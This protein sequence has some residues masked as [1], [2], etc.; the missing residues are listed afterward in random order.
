MKALIYFAI[1]YTF[2]IQ[3]MSKVMWFYFTFIARP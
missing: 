3:N 1:V 2:V